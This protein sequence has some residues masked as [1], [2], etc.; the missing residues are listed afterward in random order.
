MNKLILLALGGVASAL[1]SAAPAWAADSDAAAYRSASDKAAADYRSA[2][3]ECAKERANDKQVCLQQ[4]KVDRARADAEAVE[5]H[6]NSPTML[7]R[8]RIALAKAEYGL[9]RTRCAVMTGNDK[10]TCQRD[11]KATETAALADARSGARS[12]VMAAHV[13]DCDK[14]EASAKTACLGRNKGDTSRGSVANTAEKAKDAAVDTARSTGKVVSD[15]VITTKIKADMARDPDVSAM[16]VHVETVKGVVMLSGFV[17]SEK[18]ADR[19]VQLA[20]SV[21]GV[22]EVKNGLKVK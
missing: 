18:E 14:L 1:F 10:A 15:S 22:T 2:T 5:Q 17:N 19:A 9:A 3:A 11:A 21:E 6:R 13:E 7:S 20:R 12:S 8:A 16:D 4:A